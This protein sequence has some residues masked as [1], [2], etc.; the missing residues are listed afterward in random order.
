MYA[1]VILAIW[2]VV[3]IKLYPS[4]WHCDQTKH[5]EILSHVFDLAFSLRLKSLVGRV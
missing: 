5:V 4:S 1:P 2:C 3:A